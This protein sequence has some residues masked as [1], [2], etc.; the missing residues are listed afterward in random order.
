MTTIMEITTNPAVLTAGQVANSGLAVARDGIKDD[1][2][3]DQLENV[4][5]L[6]NSQSII[7]GDPAN[8]A[9]TV[10]MSRDALD[11]LVKT[12]QNMAIAGNQVIASCIS[13]LVDAMENTP[14]DNL[15]ELNRGNISSIATTA[16]EIEELQAQNSETSCKGRLV[17]LPAAGVEFI[18][19]ANTTNIEN[20]VNA[21][22]DSL[23]NDAGTLLLQEVTERVPTDLGLAPIGT[24]IRESNIS[25]D[26]MAAVRP[27]MQNHGQDA[28]ND[29]YLS[30]ADAFSSVDVGVTPLAF[31]KPLLDMSQ[32]QPMVQNNPYVPVPLLVTKNIDGVVTDVAYDFESALTD[33][34]IGNLDLTKSLM[35]Q[36][37]SVV[38]YTDSSHTTIVNTYSIET[39]KNI[40]EGITTAD[41]LLEMMPS[42]KVVSSEAAL[43]ILSSVGRLWNTFK[44]YTGASNAN[45]ASLIGL[46]ANIAGGLIGGSTG[47]T[48]SQIGN[49]VQQ[50]A[51][52]FSAGPMPSNLVAKW[53]P[54]NA[55]PNLTRIA[56][57]AT[58]QNTVSSTVTATGVERFSRDFS[59]SEA[60]MFATRTQSGRRNRHIS[61]V[62]SKYSK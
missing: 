4:M 8:S 39:C 42:H 31:M 47:T 32:Q 50:G 49:F 7:S 15:I 61:V 26:S 2:L 44:N 58:S 22:N 24:T 37:W 55:V 13:Q 1:G 23:G 5:S 46:G 17:L 12:L 6:V 51:A 59:N 36:D 45:I 27:V 57:T 41:N 29:M 30:S 20:V 53:M 38:L 35:D 14:S 18:S 16:H 28:V 60:T 10:R 48:I 52:A 34:D 9:V 11:R 3:L 25:L 56:Q 40:P 33:T 43:G 62:K 21:L 54:L 19:H